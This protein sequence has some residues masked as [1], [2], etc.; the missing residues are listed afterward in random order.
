MSPRPTLG[1]CWVKSLFKQTNLP[2][3][4]SQGIAGFTEEFYQTIKEE[5]IP[6]FV[7]LFIL[8]EKEGEHKSRGRAEG[9][10][11]RERILSRL[12]TVS[13]EPSAGFECTNHEIMTLAEIKSRMLN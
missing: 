12:H 9:E 1:S 13:A 8:K 5:L 4:K 11:E 7:S 2:T 10:G 6:I 3:K